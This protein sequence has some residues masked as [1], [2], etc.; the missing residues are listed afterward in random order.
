MP[1]TV[2]EWNK[3]RIKQKLLA[4]FLLISL[5]T[6]GVSYGTGLLV[7]EETERAFHTVGERILP[8]NIA[9][10]RM[11]S[12]LYHTVVLLTEYEATPTETIRTDIEASLASL[13]AYR[14]LHILYHDEEDVAKQI[15][16]MVQEFSRSVNQHL[17]LHQKGGPPQQLWE[18]RRKID[19]IMED[20]V[21]SVNPHI[22]QEFAA[23]ARQINAIKQKNQ[24]ARRVFLAV[25][26]AILLLACVLSYFIAHLLAKPLLTLRNAAQAIGGGKLDLALPITSHDEIG[27]L[28]RAFT[29]MAGNLSITHAELVAARDYINNIVASMVDALIVVAPDGTIQTVNA[30]TCFLLDYKEEELTGQPLHTV[31]ARELLPAEDL[32]ELAER[33]AI[34]DLNVEFKTR[35]GENI[36]MSISGAAMHDQTGKPLATIL[37]ARDIREMT[38]MVA[39][40]NSINRQ[41]SEEVAERTQAENALAAEKERLAV[42]LRSIGDGVITTD[43]QGRVVLLNKVAENLTGW[44]Q[45]EAEGKPLT[46]IFRII[47]SKTRAICQNPVET[48][49]ATGQVIGL[50]NHTVLIAKDGT[51]RTIADSGAPIRDWESRTIGVVLVFRDVTDEEHMEQELLKIKKL[52]SIGVLAGGIA[53]DFN[54]IL[55]AILGNID[56]ALNFI[57]PTDKTHKLLADAEKATLRAT[58]L[59]QQLLTFSKGGEPVKKLASITEIISES[60]QFVLRGSNVRCEYHFAADLWPVEIDSGQISQV[61]QNIVINADHAMPEGGIIDISCENCPLP[62]VVRLAPEL[63]TPC[64]KITVRDQGIGIQAEHLEK[65]F[66]PY[67]STKSK[68]SGLGMAITHSIISKHHGH[69]S[70][71]SKVGEGATFTILLPVAD[72][73]AISATGSPQTTFTTDGRCLRVLLMDDEEMLLVMS[74]Q[75]LAS[76][77]H[78][79]TVATDGTQAVELYRQALADG[80]PFDVTLMDLTIP[81]GMGGKEAGRIIL[82]LNPQAIMIA[83]SGYSNDPIMANPRQYGFTESIAKPYKLKELAATIAR[84]LPSLS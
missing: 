44:S 1:N 82:E 12:E 76:M 11:T 69:I 7:Q 24:H 38:Q 52:E 83:S 20:F 18:T 75:M 72:T 53:H 78:E 39:N 15:E 49:L 21:H 54:N 67:F 30:A 3:M 55:A 68:G 40:L 25:G 16:Q 6:L 47:N 73:D 43:T 33:E 65:I 63:A 71:Q 2:S 80:R 8:G 60:S 29:E 50:A 17:L 46:E 51:E 62:E 48:V 9:L 77:G 37:V 35:R 74:T 13:D 5:L 42:T 41:L 66:D 34:R 81:G 14:T 26:G 64:I 79:T 58:D 70:V 10:A 84:V 4:G 59:T 31:L 45:A 28:A 36:P 61:V 57:P 19:K 56:L 22:E 23:S 32:E 27:D